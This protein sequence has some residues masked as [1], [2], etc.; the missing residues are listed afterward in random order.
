MDN[1]KKE[2]VVILGTAHGKN[3]AGKRSPDGRLTEYMYSREV[4]GLLRRDLEGA[5]LKVYVMHFV[6]IYIQRRTLL[7][8]ILMIAEMF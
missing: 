3:V 5:G 2:K 7:V 6:S 4:V 8:L 1:K